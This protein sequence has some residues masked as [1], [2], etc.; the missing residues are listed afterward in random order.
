MVF[1]FSAVHFYNAIAGV[2]LVVEVK[3][4]IVE[5]HQE[6]HRF[7]YRSRFHQVAHRLV[8][9]F[10]KRAIAHT[11]QTRDGFDVARLDIHHNSYTKVY[12]SAPF[13]LN[14]AQAVAQRLLRNVL[15]RNVE[16]RLHV[17]AVFCR[18]VYDA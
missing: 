3:K 15:H 14:F 10:L 12:L 9:D 2:Y 7:E 1:H 8:G 18:K 13:S 5:G 4:A 17:A 16:R 6:R 11:R